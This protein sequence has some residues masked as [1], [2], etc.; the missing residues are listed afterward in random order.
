[1]CAHGPAAADE[2]YQRGE[3]EVV[4]PACGNLLRCDAAGIW[5]VA[6]PSDLLTAIALSVEPIRAQSSTMLQ[7]TSFGDP[8]PT[9]EPRRAPSALRVGC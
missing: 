7:S 8:A 2:A 4:C 9:E 5:F 1:M 6:A 3:S